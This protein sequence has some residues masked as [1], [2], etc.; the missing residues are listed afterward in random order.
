MNA[1]VERIVNLLFEDLQESEEVIALR[2]EVMNN[3]QERYRD[4]RAQG[5]GEDDAIG[6]VVESLKGMEEMLSAYPRK[7]PENRSPFRMDSFA[8]DGP[9]SVRGLRA[10]LLD[11]DLTV[12]PS[13]DGTIHCKMDG[14]GAPSIRVTQEGDCLLITQRKMDDGNG[15]P[16]GWL[17]RLVQMWTSAGCDIRLQLPEATVLSDVN[18]RTMSGDVAWRKVGAGSLEIRTASGDVTVERTVCSGELRVHSASGE[19]DVSG[20]SKAVSLET[21]S[22]D[23]SWEGC[24]E[25]IFCKSASGDVDIAGAFL[26]LEANSVSGDV[27][28]EAR[29]ANIQEIRTKSVSGDVEVELPDGV[30]AEVQLSSVSGSAENHTDSSA[31]RTVKIQASSVSGDVTVS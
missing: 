19:I 15:S 20:E 6:Q 16:M 24:A 28:I 5:L 10:E 17:G 18:V 8:K 3:C 29:D 11:A 26:K 1:T 12:E 23:I 25:K 2:E 27:D 4:L 7:Q 30:G 9:G 13:P 31:A 22:G 21:M 14:E